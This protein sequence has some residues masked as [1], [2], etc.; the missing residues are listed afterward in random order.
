[1]FNTGSG[2]KLSP[3]QGVVMR[4]SPW[5]KQLPQAPGGAQ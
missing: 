2:N 5:V 4:A 3:S 1:M